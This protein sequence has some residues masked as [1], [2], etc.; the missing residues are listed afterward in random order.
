MATATFRCYGSLN[1]FISPKRRHVP[2]THT[3]GGRVSVKDVIESLGIPHPEVGL[4]LINSQSA[5]FSQVL[6]EG[7]YVS[8]YPAF[9]E[10]DVSA[11]SLVQ[12]APLTAVRFVLDV[13][14]GTLASHLRLMGFDTLYRNDYADEELARISHNERRILLT[15]DRGLLMRSLVDYGY[16]VRY[17]NPPRQ[18][19][20]VLH[21]FTLVDS[22]RPF[23]R[24]LACNG[25]LTPV[26]K[27]AVQEQ[28]PPNVLTY[29][30]QFWRCRQCSRVY[31]EGTHHERMLRFVDDVRQRL[32]R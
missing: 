1:D 29:R 17:T 4:L 2:F 27:A 24:C 32:S 8:V 15:R 9:A 6:R 13:H 28:L 3:V 18:L 26:D 19:I 12:P 20:E 7:D 14:L 31:W 5:A 23:T 16:F 25:A 11:V 10:L 22:L 21:R 30:H